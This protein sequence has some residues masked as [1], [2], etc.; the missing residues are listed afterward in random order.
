MRITVSVQR[1]V[2]QVATIEVEA[3][4]VEDAVEAAEDMV[5]SDDPAIAWTEGGDTVDGAAAEVG[6]PAYT[7]TD[8][9]GEHTWNRD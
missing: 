8:A 6:G 2:E 7:A 5:R 1:Y 4:S 9:S 3:D